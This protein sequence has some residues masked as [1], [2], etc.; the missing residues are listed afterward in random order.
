MRKTKIKNRI[1]INNI[2]PTIKKKIGKTTPTGPK[3]F[4]R[5]NLKNAVG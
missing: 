4:N 2:N 3:V 5:L 1:K